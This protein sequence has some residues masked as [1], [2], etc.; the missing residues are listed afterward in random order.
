[1]IHCEIY[2]EIIYKIN[3]Y[4]NFQTV[5]NI[6]ITEINFIH[7]FHFALTY[8]NIDYST[9]KIC[10]F[11]NKRITNFKNQSFSTVQKPNV[12]LALS[13]YSRRLIYKSARNTHLF[14]E[15]SLNRLNRKSSPKLR[16]LA[17]F[18]AM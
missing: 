13:H 14:T 15:A 16:E 17:L 18:R 1:M 5:D 7:I 8:N 10:K 9:I 12:S 6:L 3:E 11:W 4:N 2:S